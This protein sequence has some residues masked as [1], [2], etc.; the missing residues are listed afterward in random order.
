VIGALVI[1][2]TLASPAITRPTFPAA[3]AGGEVIADI[4]VH[5]NLIVP[6]N[7][8]L[9]IA[10]VAVG[11]AFGATTIA[12]VTARLRASNRFHEIQVLKRYASISDPTRIVLVLVVNEGAVRVET[13]AGP[14]GPV[15]VV[16]R[17]RWRGL[18][19]MPILY[20]EDGYGLTYGARLAYAGAAGGRSRLSF[21]LTWGGMK[22]AGAEIERSFDRGPFTRVSGG[23]AVQRQKNPAYSAD[24][25]RQRVWARVERADGPLRVG[26]TTGWQRVTFVGVTD[27]VRST[28]ADVAV[29]TRLDPILPRNAVYASASIEHLTF[30][31]RESVN[32]TKLEARGYLGLNGQNVLALRAVR[33]DS[34]RPLPL[35]FRSLLGGWSNLRGF[36][37]GAFTGDTMVAGSIELRVPLSSPL[38]VGKL[39]V[40]AFVDTGTAYDKGERFQD[41]PHHVGIGGSVWVTAAVFQM[42][43]SV[44]HGRHADTRVNFGLGTSF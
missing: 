31:V 27:R 23:A 15:S 29:D 5:G 13:P 11:D 24:D 2:L 3:Q 4:Q 43:L 22:R 44:A 20:G 18:M 41:Q 26:G 8:V 21:P 32:R 33:E 40:S 14:S 28:G 17:A 25:D 30:D 38:N 10:G 19:F 16:K 6:N 39:G 1:A 34:D 9:K 7:E 36:K 35:Y 42:S 37:A 12:E